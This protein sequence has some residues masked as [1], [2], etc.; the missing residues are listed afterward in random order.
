MLN[1]GKN[2]KKI[3]VI[4]KGT[5]F[6]KKNS[7]SLDH[8]DVLFKLL[9][10][11]KP[12][13]FRK[14]AG[15]ENTN[16]KITQKHFFIIVVENLL[17]IAVIN[18]WGLAIKD[19]FIYLFNGAFWKPIEFNQF[20]TFLGKAAQ[21]MGV[22]QYFA[23]YYQF[24]DN[25][26]KQFLALGVLPIPESYKNG[27]KIN[28]MNGTFVISE[29]G[30]ELRDFERDD[31]LTYQLPFV[32]D[33]NKESPLFNSY[34]DRVL[35]ENE[36]QQ[37]LAQYIGY[38]FA[39]NLKLE[40]ALLLYG[41]GA[42]GKS[43]F[44]DIIQALLGE[45]N[46]SNYS[47]ESL[48]H[49]YYR[50]LLTNKLLNYG[51]ELNGNI[52]ADL[53]K[54]LIS[55]EPTS[56]RLPYGQPFIIRDYAKLCFNANELPKEIEHSEA[57]FRR[58]IIIPFKVTIQEG[59][60]DPELSKK[61]IKNELSG[62]FNWVLKGLRELLEQKGFSQNKTLKDEVKKFQQESDT[63]FLFM[64]ED[65]YRASIDDYIPLK[66]LY[67]NYKSFC[68]DGGFKFLN[69]LN[70]RRRLENRGITVERK[71]EGKVVY[72]KKFLFED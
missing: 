37:I 42:N 28:L 70:F 35:P 14:E 66:E 71:K 11:I 57:Y 8:Q 16:K 1:Q 53:L 52:K 12:V 3:V 63:C 46:I 67:L 2:S 18:N 62:V 58:F 30:Q 6:N 44:F 61:I 29:D 32:Y 19:N 22:D 33:T 10:K 56:A 23:K 45:A 48:G 51:S 9:T 47:L 40:K 41:S 26:L 4:P 17:D 65:G 55:G 64:D 34:L 13:N 15:I 43:V 38:I 54:L 68:N 49:E 7:E 5:D 31:F 59:E 36:L 25:L 27:V 50:A 69:Q 21:Q 39:V 60:R 20:K 72:V 24:R